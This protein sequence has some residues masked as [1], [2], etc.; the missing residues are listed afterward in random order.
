MWAFRFHNS[1]G[2]D[3]WQNSPSAVEQGCI[4]NQQE[5]SQWERRAL[6][7]HF[8]WRGAQPCPV[9]LEPW[10]NLRKTPPFLLWEKMRGNPEGK[11]LPEAFFSLNAPNYYILMWALNKFKTCMNPL[12]PEQS[13][14][15]KD[16]D[17]T[18]PG[19]F[20]S[21]VYLCILLCEIYVHSSLS[22]RIWF[23]E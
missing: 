13:A 20:S 15:G 5:E 17:M 9:C 7:R 10:A 21:L 6:N 3:T 2:L 11:M 14:P 12:S 16:G 4:L 18:I 23:V 19:N 22:T 8:K 1:V